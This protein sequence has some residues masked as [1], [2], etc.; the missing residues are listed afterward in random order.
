M[1]IDNWSLSIDIHI[2]FLLKFKHWIFII[3]PRAITVT[4]N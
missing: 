2:Y 1:H 3:T 4:G